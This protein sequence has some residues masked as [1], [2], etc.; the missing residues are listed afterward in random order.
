MKKI[1]FVIILLFF[2]PITFAQQNTFVKIAGDKQLGLKDIP[3]KEEFTIQLLD[4]KK[5][6][7]KNTEVEFSIIQDSIL[8]DS[9]NLSYLQKHKISTNENGYAKT[10]LVIGKKSDEKII[11]LVT[12]ENT[13]P[14]YFTVSVLGKNWLLLMFAGI[15]GG[16]A[17][18][19]F[20]MFKI[21]LAFEKIVGQNMRTI[22]TNFTSTKLKGF[23]TGLSI[24][25]LNQ[26][27]SATALLQISLVSAGLLSFQQ[28]MAVTMGSSIGSTI[29]GQL[30]AFR[31]V[32][33]AL[34][35]VSLGFF[36][37]FFSSKKKIASFGDIIFGFGLLFFSMK[38]MSDSMLP[39]TLNTNL[40]DT[41][42]TIKSP[43]FAIFVGFCFT[44]LIQSSGATVGIT[45]VLAS[46]GILSLMQAICI[47]LGAQVGTCITSVIASINQ[48]RAGRRVMLWHFTFQTLGV[49]IIMPLLF[50]NYNDNPVWLSFTKFITNKILHSNDI[51][52]EIA[53][54]HTMVAIIT[55]LA[56]LPV[57]PLFY[58]LILFIYPRKL[59]ENPTAPIFIDDKYISQTN[60]A[61]ELSKK[62][63][64]RVS[65]ILMEIVK[66][67]IR[68]LETRHEEIGEK[69]AS[70]AFRIRLLTSKIVPYLSKIGQ[71]QLS[72][73]QS[74]HE[75]SLLYI[76]ADFEQIADIIERN[77]MFVAHEKIKRNLR[78]S[79]EGLNDIRQ[80][81]NIISSNC[82]KVI[83]S[84]DKDD[85]VTAKEIINSVSELHNTVHQF[86][87]KHIT[88]LQA[89]LQESIETS[90]LH[91]DVLD[92]Y[93]RINDILADIASTVSKQ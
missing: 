78:F 12:S 24:T 80:L 19:L 58:K 39:V 33:Y 32:D 1:Y 92:Q 83:N 31:L 9:K 11:V 67:S 84:F 70:Q 22:L 79:D 88:R 3:L 7:L 38:I 45:I 15:L 30:V 48:T 50:I 46:S 63:I 89:G 87:K 40:L 86:K 77:L 69:I 91:M 73:Q 56:V 64:L 6:P 62:E 85:I 41:I 57:L 29:T 18:L 43:I 14:V 36:I 66:G 75:I 60:K 28:S 54:S 93:T 71:N 68:L 37:S 44:V 76:I 61:L 17:L 8:Q 34:L 5:Q 59:S 26:S 4:T 52:R 27:S 21:N 51:A 25:G 20:S 10:K 53:M 81:H 49:L 55:S 72:Q 47:C 82:S 23:L 90:G 16:T 13:K 74:K 2:A 65:E 42:A 35:I